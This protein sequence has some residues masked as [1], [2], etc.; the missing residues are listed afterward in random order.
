[1]KSPESAG[2]S[3]SAFAQGLTSE[4]AFDVLA[5]A[6]RLK[7]AGKDVIELQIGD[8]PFPS[9]ASALAAG[10]AAI[11]AGATHYCPSLGVPEFR[12]TVADNFT[13]EFGV[14]ATADNVII[15]P[16]AKP[17][18]QFFCEA[19]LD[20]GDEVLLF[21]PQFPT[22][23]PNVRRRGAVCVYSTLRAENQFRPDLG[24][25]RRFLEWSSRPK[26][27]FLN[28][29]HNPT[30]G[31]AT[32]E[33]LR[34]LA[35]LIRSRDVALFSDEPYCHMVWS[36][37]HHTILAEP[38]MMDQC[39][40]AYT[41]SKSYSMSGWRVGYA[42][43]GRRVIEVM[44]KMVN[45]TLSCVPPIVQW[46]A[47]SALEQDAGE[48][49]AVMAK[50]RRKVELLVAELRGLDEVRVAMPAGTFYVFPDVSRIC[51][52]LGITSHGLAMYLL[53]GADDRAGVA[54]LGGEC[55]G[56]AGQGYLRFSCA[57]PDERLTEAIR[58]LADA[59]TRTERVERYLEG[60]PKY[61]LSSSPA[62]GKG[63][64]A[65]V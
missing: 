59:V 60:H 44:G 12:R 5:V 61:R 26:A 16:G 43:A 52:R 31:V 58:F 62:V 25:V 4:T 27:I 48:R 2:P 35:D 41:F 11:D 42:V 17:F 34:G 13:R 3:L 8:S 55:F 36:G 6:R 54:C 57:E 39:V 10:R 45:T 18:E 14:P 7:A 21:S 49:D 53:E 50:F 51:R 1:M 37:R 56:P 65:A 30:G 15:G 46:A 63:S 20:P 40:A 32:A 64:P 22:Y 9:T 24:D 38:G 23:E 47:K 33:D 28:S 19:F 29:P